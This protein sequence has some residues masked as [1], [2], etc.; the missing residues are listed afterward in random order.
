MPARSWHSGQLVS[1]FATWIDLGAQVQLV[2]TF[3]VEPV[4]MTSS[5]YFD[6]ICTLPLLTDVFASA[7][8][9]T[10]PILTVGL[11]SGH[12]QTYRL[13]STDESTP[14]PAVEPRRQSTDG[15]NSILSQRRRSST[16]SENGLGSIDTIW[17]TRRHKGSCRA[18]AYNPDG[19]VC[20][21]GGTDGLVKAFDSETGKVTSKIAIPVSSSSKE[22]VDAPTV[23]HV[24]TP[25]H[26]IIAT[27]SG[28]VYIFDLKDNSRIISSKPSKIL[29][30]HKD[31]HVNSLIPIPPTAAS[32]S[33]FPKQFV[34]VGGSTLAVIDLRKGIIATSEDQETELSSLCI[35]DGLKTG[36]T[37]VGS[38]VLVGQSD[39]IISLF[40]RGVWGDLDER[41]IVDKAGASI[42]AL[43][44]VPAIF[45]PKAGKLKMSEKVVAAGLDDGTVRFIR[46]GRNAVIHEWDLRHDDIEGV[47]SIAFDESG[48]RM[49]TGGGQSVKVWTKASAA[50]EATINTNGKRKLET[51]GGTDSDEDD[52]VNEDSSEQEQES[53][54]EIVSEEDSEKEEGGKRKKRKRNRGKDKTGGRVLK[55]SGMF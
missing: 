10:Q 38:K 23:L 11:A 15:T 9:P 32:T 7:L 54:D 19:T 5:P 40:E 14:L 33:G 37:S 26:L 42:D 51:D 29:H 8:H 17:K 1:W 45:L 31:E 50:V 16:A 4:T 30:P 41:V 43:C 20:F 35:V 6:N 13:P 28:A 49:I 25:L 27:D 44:E 12:V 24:L 3:A 22:H 47:T 48:T 34:T 21:S 46:V 2:R 39:G 36:G 18:L 52:D 53:E 55:L